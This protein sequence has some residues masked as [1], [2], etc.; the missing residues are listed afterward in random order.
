M[1]LIPILLLTLLLTGCKHGDDCAYVPGQA[2]VIVDRPDTD[3][4]AVPEPA[5]LALMTIGLMGLILLSKRKLNV[6][7]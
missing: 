4:H 3:P 6:K 1:K 5:T 2:Q 7:N